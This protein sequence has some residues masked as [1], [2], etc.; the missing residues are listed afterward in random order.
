MALQIIKLNAGNDTNGN[1]RRVFVA[2][3]NGVAVNSWDE[4]Y[5]GEH[6]VSEQYRRCYAG[7]T[8]ETTPKE[9]R[10]L[11]KRFAETGDD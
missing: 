4:G 2:L 10:S 1:P 7:Q 5:E 9:Y 6:A 8:F 11:V 3:R